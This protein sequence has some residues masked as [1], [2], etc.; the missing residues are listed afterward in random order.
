MCGRYNLN[1]NDDFYKRFGLVNKLPSFPKN[2]EVSP[3]QIEPVITHENGSNLVWTMKWGM[4]PFWAKERGVG[5]KMFNVRAE[6]LTTKIGFRKSFQTKRCLVPSNGFYE[7]KA[8][9]GIKVPYLIKVKDRPLF[10]FAGVYDIWQEPVSGREVYSY[11]IITTKPN[12]AIKPI[13]DRMPVILQPEQEKTWLDQSVLNIK[14]ETLLH[15][16]SEILTINQH[17]F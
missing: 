14:L 3:G 6:S 9:N 1:L 13:H 16:S 5:N 17:K 8:E 15:P 4:I 11:A 7:W 12:S 10:A 2:I